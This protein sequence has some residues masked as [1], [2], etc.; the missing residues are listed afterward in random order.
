MR[1][2][3]ALV[4]RGRRAAESLM[5]T[6]ATVDRPGK[7]V[8]AAD[9]TVSTPLTRVYPTPAELSAGNPGRCKVQQ[10]ISQASNPVAGGH[11]FT[12]QDARVDLPI[13]AG[14]FGVGD[15]ITVTGSGNNPHLVGNVYTVDEEFEKEH[16]S[17]Q[18]LRVKQVTA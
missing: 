2:V 10:T 9:G 17:S 3:G 18:R 4:A 5:D 1:R 15:V 12:V 8:T 6:T 11:I 14:P 13:S 16:L 7:A